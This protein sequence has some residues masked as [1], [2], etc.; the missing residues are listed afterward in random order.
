[1]L[2]WEKNDTFG[3]IWIKNVY[4][5]K[6][7]ESIVKKY[8]LLPPF[9]WELLILTFYFIFFYFQIN[10][11][12]QLTHRITSF[13]LLFKSIYWTYSMPM[14]MWHIDNSA[15]TKNIYMALYP[16][17]LL[18]VVTMNILKDAHIIFEA[19]S[20]IFKD[21]SKGLLISDPWVWSSPFLDKILNWVFTSLGEFP[22]WVI[23]VILKETI[24]FHSSLCLRG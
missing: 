17:L 21:I 7:I 18:L 20:T 24:F 10:N 4:I 1:M 5:L 6:N 3:H 14:A 23:F 12:S 22:A 15:V 2:K 9:I 13:K 16:A 19:L 8:I 11:T